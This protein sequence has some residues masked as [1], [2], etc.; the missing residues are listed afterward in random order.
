MTQTNICIRV[1]ENLKKQFDYLCNELGLTMSTAINMFL[2]TVVRENRIPF[3]LSL[4]IPNAV[5]KQAFKDVENGIIDSVPYRNSKEVI[6]KI[7][8]DNNED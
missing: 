4:E 1:D 2:K 7:L 3:E 5:T 6:Q 8:K